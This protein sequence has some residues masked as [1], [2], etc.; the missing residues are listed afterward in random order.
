[1]IRIR[2]KV[3]PLIWEPR[4]TP[5]RRPPVGHATKGDAIVIGLMLALVLTT[6]VLG[7]IFG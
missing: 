3:G 2:F 5:D 7:L 4:H 6:T 1:M